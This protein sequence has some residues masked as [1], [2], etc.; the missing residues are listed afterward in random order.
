MRLIIPI[1]QLRERLQPAKIAVPHRLRF[2]VHC[3]P[4][5]RVARDPAAHPPLNPCHFGWFTAR[6]EI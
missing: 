5:H 3:M 2:E 1:L 6:G 4:S